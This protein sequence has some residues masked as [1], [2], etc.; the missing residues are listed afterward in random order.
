[1]RSIRSA[2]WILLLAASGAGVGGGTAGTGPRVVRMGVNDSRS[3]SIARRGAANVYEFTIT[4]PGIFRFAVRNIPDAVRL[5]PEIAE[6]HMLLSGPGGFNWSRFTVKDAKHFESPPFALPNGTYRLTIKDYFDDAASL[7]SYTL[8]TMF[9]EVNDPGEPNDTPAAATALEAGRPR[10]GYILPAGDVDCYRMHLAE[11]GRV[12][13]TISNIPREI[14]ESRG[15]KALYLGI[16]DRNGRMLREFSSSFGS[17]TLKTGKMV[18]N[19]G[20]YFLCVRDF[21]G[22]DFSGSPYTIVA[23]FPA[24]KG[25]ISPEEK[26][27]LDAVRALL[28]R[29]GDGLDTEERQV[30]KR[31]ERRFLK[32]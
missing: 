18:M 21:D 9:Q 7:E 6:L 14:R 1:M 28:T 15:M 13:V 11:P 10:R 30:L 8:Q 29:S 22:Q 3:G 17:H 32:D 5:G 23:D 26:A 25:T 19:V 24:P 4:R 20:T 27:L 16:L 2:A 31:L 12:E